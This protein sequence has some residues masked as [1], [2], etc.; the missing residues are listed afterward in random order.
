MKRT[1]IISLLTLFVTCFSHFSYSCHLISITETSATDNGN[2]TYT[3][4]F[5]VCVG[6]ENT[7]GFYLSFTGANLLSFPGSV[8]GPTTG[9]TIFGSDPPL[10]G[11]GDVDYGD[12]DNALTPVFSD[13]NQDCFSMTFTFDGPISDATVGGTQIQFLPPTGCAPVTTPTTDCFGPSYVVTINT[14]DYGAESTWNFVNQ[15]TGSIVASGGPYADNA[16]I[17]ANLCLP[18]DCYDFNMFDSFGDGMCCAYGIGS[19]SVTDATSTVVASG[20]SFGFSQT[21]PIICPVLSIE[22]SDFEVTNDEGNENKVEWTVTSQE[23]NDYFLIE[24]SDD[25]ENWVTVGEVEGAGT[26]DEELRYEVLDDDYRWV[27]NYY[28]LSQIDF[29]ATST[30]YEP[31]SIDNSVKSVQMIGRTNYLG[32]QVDDS[33]QGLVIEYYSD[34]TITRTYAN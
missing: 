10:S 23:N 11:T 21:T 17:V 13:F 2:G 6:T 9:V 31:K 20:G 25:L 34:G 16:T 32:Q 24:R 26:T 8:T 5:D 7:F 1:L 4:T 29:D 12:W 30:V 22:L 18:I 27:I 3:Y 33:Y 19:Y 28:R 14:D 15:A